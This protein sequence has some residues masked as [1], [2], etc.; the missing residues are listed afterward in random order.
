MPADQNKNTLARQWEMLKLLPSRPPGMTA[1]DITQHLSDKGYEV[2]KRTVERDLQALSG[3]FPLYCNDRSPPFGWYFTPGTH[4]DIPGFT[5]SE[6]LTLKLVEQYLTPLLPATM[7]STLHGHFEQATRKLDALTD[8]PAARWTEKIRSVPP[9]Q[10]LVSPVIDHS[11]L[12]TLQ[13]A[14]LTERQVEVGYKKLRADE[15][16]TYTLHPLGLLQRGPVM[17]LVATAFDYT[18]PRLYAVHRIRALTLL[19]APLQRPAG[20]DLDAYIRQGGANFG[21]GETIALELRVHEDLAANL[22]EAPLSADMQVTR[23]EDGIRVKAT[24]PDTWQLRWWLLSQAGRVEVVEP[25]SVRAAIRQQLA[26][27]LAHYADD[28]P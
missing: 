3:S 7:L 27:A 24:L 11:V 1:R 28:A 13:H 15:L 20:F 26:E 22:A 12:E 8:N 9:A 6:A 5:I 21:A 10:P 18:D 19:D 23:G 25:A 14:L 17:Y 2:T 4:L 16:A